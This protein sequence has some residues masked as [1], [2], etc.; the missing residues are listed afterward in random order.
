MMSLDFVCRLLLRA[1]W[2]YKTIFISFILKLQ[3]STQILDLQWNFY[4]KNFPI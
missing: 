3:I 2:D 1:E 4:I